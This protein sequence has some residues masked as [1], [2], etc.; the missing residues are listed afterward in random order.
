MI[1]FSPYRDVSGRNQSNEVEEYQLLV[2]QHR[3]MVDAETAAPAT[4]TASHKPQSI[5]GIRSFR[6]HE[7]SWGYG[8]V[9]KVLAVQV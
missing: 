9:H 3:T 5:R 2:S 1:Y 7:N 4:V 6:N 8:S